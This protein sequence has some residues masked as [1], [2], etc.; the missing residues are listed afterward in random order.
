MSRRSDMVEVKVMSP[1]MTDETGKIRQMNTDERAAYVA[2]TCRSFAMRDPPV[3][4]ADDCGRGGD[5]LS[6]DSRS[7]E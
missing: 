7:T 6:T 3:K 1:R 5:E 4:N 2:A